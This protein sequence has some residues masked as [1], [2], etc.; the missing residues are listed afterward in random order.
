ALDGVFDFVARKR[1][2]STSYIKELHA[3][4]VRSHETRIPLLKGDWKTQRNFPTREG[5]VYA[6]CPPEQV[7]SEMDRLVGLHAEYARQG[8]DAAVRS[9]WLHHR[10]TQIHPFQDGNGRVARAL[11]TLVLV[12]AGLFPFVVTR[13]DKA[14]YLDALE[15][16][17]KGDL[18]PLVGLMA[19]SQRTQFRKATAISETM[20]ADVAQ[21]LELLRHAAERRAGDGFDHARRLRDDVE[22]RLR[23]LVPEV[24]AALGRLAPNANALV[25]SSDEDAS[26]LFRSQI[27]ENAARLG[28]VADTASHQSWVRLDM[29]WRRR[30]RLV[31]T[32]HGIGARFSGGLVCAPFLEFRD[33]DDGG[34]R[35][36]LVP[37]ADEPF[38]FFRDEADGKVLARFHE[39]RER[40]LTTAL[41]ELSRNL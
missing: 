25:A 6:Y 7:A 28:Y 1:E 36:T 19:R 15:A 27:A 20:L 10:F 26:R 23:A 40:V 34:S 31:F 16:G 9:A 33:D 2:L 37:V 5:T 12:Q 21:G 18:A 4:L 39:W 32:F 24:T 11:A 22:S 3:A 14:D 38:M 8:V 17:D 35:S 30:A 13:D 29:A 41:G